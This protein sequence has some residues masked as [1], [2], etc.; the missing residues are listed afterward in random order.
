MQECLND[1]DIYLLLDVYLEKT[2]FVIIISKFDQMLLIDFN[3]QI[4][5]FKIISYDMTY[6]NLLAKVREREREKKRGVEV[7]F[8]LIFAKAFL[9]FNKS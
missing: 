5:N 8:R 2:L 1:V 3:D 4:Q 7:K 6:F 9:S